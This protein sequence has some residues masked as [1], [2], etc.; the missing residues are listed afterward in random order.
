MGVGLQGGDAAG[1][2]HEEMGSER[3]KKTHKKCHPHIPTLQDSLI[4]SKSF[5]N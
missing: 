2:T 5:L 4:K 1:G 3:N